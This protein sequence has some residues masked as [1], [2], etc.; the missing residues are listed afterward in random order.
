MIIPVPK[1]SVTFGLVRFLKNQIQLLHVLGTGWEMLS[2]D[3]ISDK[4]QQ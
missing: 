3:R 2:L 1:G 4:W